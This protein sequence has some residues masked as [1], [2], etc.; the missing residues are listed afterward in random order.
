[1]LFTK[2]VTGNFSFHFVTKNTDEQNNTFHNWFKVAL[3]QD[4]FDCLAEIGRLPVATTREYIKEIKDAQ[5][6][7]EL[8]E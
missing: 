3:E 7:R 2:T 8:Y 1:M 5:E 6:I 4:F